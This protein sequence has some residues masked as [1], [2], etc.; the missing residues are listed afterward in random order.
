[1]IQQRSLM[2]ARACFIR[3][4]SVKFDGSSPFEKEPLK[5]HIQDDI[6]ELKW[7]TPLGEKPDE[8][9]SKFKLFATEK[10]TNSQV[11]TAMQQPFDFSISGIKK[12]RRNKAVKTEIFMQQFIPERHDILGNDLA[13]AHFVVHR[14]GSVR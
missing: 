5:K 13:A 2:L 14:G 12:H 9:Y 3:N 10:D 8:W 7:R 6:D 4:F 11:L 1:M